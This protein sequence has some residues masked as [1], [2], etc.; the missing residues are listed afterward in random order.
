MK[1]INHHSMI[2]RSNVMRYVVMD[3][4]WALMNA[5]MAILSTKMVALLLAG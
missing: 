1:N 5:M 4:I 3:S 2:R